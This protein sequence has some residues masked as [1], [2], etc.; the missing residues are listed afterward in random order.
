MNPI[1]SIEWLRE[2]Q[3]EPGL[4]IVDCRF[5]M[6]KPNTGREAYEEAHIPGAVYID[7]EKDLSAP[8]GKHG[9]RHPLPDPNS[10]AE[11][12]GQL[13]IGNDSRIV[14]YDDQGGAMASR[15]WW[16]LAYL[17]HDE[18]YLLD[19]GFAAWQ[20]AGLPV[21]AGPAAS[22]AAK[23]FK[24]AVR[25][26]ILASAEEVRGKLGQAGVVLVDSREAPRYR[27]ESEPIDSVAGHIPGAI[28][29]FWGEGWRADGVWKSADEQAARFAGLPVD[30]EII[31][32]C[33]SGV[34]ATPN[35]LALCQAGFTRVKLYAGSWSDWISY[36]ENPIAVGE[37]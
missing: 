25:D 17:G 19:R 15:F 12:L 26:G 32:Y 18:V 10:L 1:V 4:R 31:V 11:R 33:G 23:R 22:A 28:N 13:G 30:D 7:L 8:V 37:E 27:G 14:A 9:G 6:G 16:L 34:T 24:P 5:W 20:E 2:R 29:R 3:N 35:V 21:Q 36:E